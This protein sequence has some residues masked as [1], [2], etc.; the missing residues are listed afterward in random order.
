MPDDDMEQG[1]C[2][3]SN[4]Q[5]SDDKIIAAKTLCAYLLKRKSNSIIISHYS[6]KAQ[7]VAK[8]DISN[9]FSICLEAQRVDALSFDGSAKFV[10][11]FPEPLQFRE[12]VRIL[13]PRARGRKRVSVW[14]IVAIAKGAT[15]LQGLLGTANAIPAD[16][17]KKEENFESQ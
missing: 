10:N 8:K 9:F 7:Q 13:N 1:G 17:P 15:K 4:Q 3:D 6:E 16:V 12:D 2:A 14:S 5:L 11:Q